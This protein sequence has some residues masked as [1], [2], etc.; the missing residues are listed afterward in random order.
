MVLMVSPCTPA[1]NFLGTY[2]MIGWRQMDDLKS[3]PF[4]AVPPFVSM[5]VLTTVPGV[6]YWNICNSDSQYFPMVFRILA[7]I[8][9]SGQL[10]ISA[11]HYLFFPQRPHGTTLWGAL[12]YST[13]LIPFSGVVVFIY[14]ANV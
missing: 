7:L 11:P 2:F 9:V 12:F 1:K 3:I 6:M 5:V 14:I 8:P 4:G 10:H 13:E